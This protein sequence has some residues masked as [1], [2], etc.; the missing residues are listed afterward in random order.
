MN[1]DFCEHKEKTSEC[2]LETKLYCQECQVFLCFA[3]MVIFHKNHKFMRYDEFTG[4]ESENKLLIH[5][6]F[7]NKEKDINNR[8]LKNLFFQEYEK[9]Y[10]RKIDLVKQTMSTNEEESKNRYEDVTNCF[11]KFLNE[12]GNFEKQ[13]FDK[14]K[15]TVYDKTL[16]NQKMLHSNLIQG[17]ICSF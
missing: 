11:I 5:K 16:E 3:C 7:E 1:K 14:F 2:L 12:L 15:N 9:I 4:Q 10:K 13:I 8:C 17:K 6:F